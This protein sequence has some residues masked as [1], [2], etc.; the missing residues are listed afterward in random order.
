MGGKIITRLNFVMQSIYFLYFR[1][2][3]DTIQ[4]MVKID[5]FPYVVHSLEA[6]GLRIVMLDLILSPLTQRV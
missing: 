6:G 4:T 3:E 5:R 2:R 1:S